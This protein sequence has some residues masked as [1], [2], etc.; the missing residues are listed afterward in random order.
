MKLRRNASGTTVKCVCAIFVSGYAEAQ[1][2]MVNRLYPMTFFFCIVKA[3]PFFL[4]RHD[5]PF[6]AKMQTKKE[7]D[8]YAPLKIISL[9]G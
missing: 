6:F 3:V 5:T 1:R 7:R 2:N 9:S 4:F 8:I